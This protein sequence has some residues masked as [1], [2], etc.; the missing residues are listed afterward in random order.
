MELYTHTITNDQ[1]SC[2]LLFVSFYST[3]T[4]WLSF[5]VHHYETVT[6]KVCSPLFRGHLTKS[7][8]QSTKFNSVKTVI[9]LNQRLCFPFIYLA[10]KDDSVKQLVNGTDISALLLNLA[11]YNQSSV[12]QWPGPHYSWVQFNPNVW[13]ETL[14]ALC[15]NNHG[16]YSW[17]GTS[18]EP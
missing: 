15:K 11:Y 10:E 18:S 3:N 6:S 8:L 1:R 9:I 14:N 4:I 7:V 17:T 12:L 5:Q 2:N 16:A 13:L